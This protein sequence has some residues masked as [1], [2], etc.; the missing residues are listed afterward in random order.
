MSPR[1]ELQGTSFKIESVQ[2]I[3]PTLQPET[4]STI[5]IT[6]LA[7]EV[8]AD[9]RP[10]INKD[11]EPETRLGLLNINNKNSCRGTVENPSTPT[12]RNLERFDYFSCNLKAV[13][14]MQQNVSPTEQA[15][16]TA[17]LYALGLENINANVFSRENGVLGENLKDKNIYV[18]LHGWTGN[19]S[20]YTD[21]KQENGFSVVEEIMAKD[22][23]AI[24][25][26]MDGNGFGETNF[27]EDII[28]GDLQQFCTPEAY[29]K[30]TDFFISQ[31]LGIE[32]EEKNNVSIMGH[33]MGG[34]ATLIL[35]AIY[36]YE[37]TMA[38]SPA[39][40]PTKE[41]LSEIEAEFENPAEATKIENFLKKM[42]YRTAGDGRYAFVGA[43]AKLG[44]Y[45]KRVMPKITDKA[46]QVFYDVV[47]A[48][49]MGEEVT[50][51]E[52]VDLAI[53]SKLIGI[54]RGELSSHRLV[55]LAL[56]NLRRGVDFSKWSLLEV[57]RLN[58]TSILTSKE[59][60]LVTT[61]D[62]INF[63]KTIAAYELTKSAALGVENMT[64]EEL[65]SIRAQIEAI[66]RRQSGGFAERSVLKGGHYASVYNE[67][68][69][70]T[71][72]HGATKRRRIKEEQT[73]SII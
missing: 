56:T 65:S 55:D 22:P 47:G 43:I 38:L 18:L 15:E 68:A 31:V 32:G 19:N 41:N 23:N 67:I 58:R 25:V 57:E 72:V 10:E 20:I 54:H 6:T 42:G 73:Q 44:S 48:G 64:E 33:S 2:K 28:K 63:L 8:G 49:Y 39:L 14:F 69:V 13:E 30:Q 4:A 60:K 62:I 70:N 71:I 52:E 46:T 11:A 36:G 7:P 21:V 50:G 5:P 12:E 1:T 45:T 27:R 17:G 24:V 26:T 37:N 40:F 53:V 51:N 35:A 3:T 61:E 16:F 34:A 59:D 29:A 66:R 9:T